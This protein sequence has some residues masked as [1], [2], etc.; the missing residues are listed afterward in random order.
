MTIN[1]PHP[2]SLQPLA[3]TNLL[4][5]SMDLPNLDIS[6]KW[7]HNCGLLGPL[8]LLSVVSSRVIQGCSCINI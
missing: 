2:P 8:L 6:Y 3:T 4:S 1:I 7:N 5:V